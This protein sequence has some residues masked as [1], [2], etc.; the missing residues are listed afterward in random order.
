[1]KS[2]PAAA[3]HCRLMDAIIRRRGSGDATLV[4]MS[5]SFVDCFERSRC[6][7]GL[8]PVRNRRRRDLN[9]L[10]LACLLCL[11]APSA[12]GATWTVRSQPIRPVNG[13][14]VFFQV[15]APVALE[16]LTGTWLG[17]E[18]PFSFDQSTKTWFAL[19]G[20]SFET[21]P[22]KYD[23]QLK[24]ERHGVETAL[25][26]TRKVSIAAAHYPKIRA[27]LTVEGKFTEPSP[28]QVK[29][30]EEDAK[31]KQD[32]LNRITPEREWS[33]NF[34]APA[35]AENSDVFGSQRIFNDKAQRPHLGLDYRV[36]TG[37]PVAAMNAGTVLLARPLY[38]EGNC[39]VIDH[40]QGLLTLYLHLSEFKVTEGEKVKR[41][42]E[43][44]RALIST[45]R[46]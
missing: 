31:T 18:I 3:I 20:V 26:F 42:Q 23:L 4:R 6:A 8:F 13:S 27:K 38:F 11:F 24:G 30:I 29:H 12:F 44:G 19:A 32:Y 35:E 9:E 45:R 37:T 43:V 14:P 2:I 7:F 40:G 17:H 1:M 10:A 25:A 46:A 28:E 33:G 16:T 39:V 36:P 21:K 22:G 34:A 41:G 15:K 5:N